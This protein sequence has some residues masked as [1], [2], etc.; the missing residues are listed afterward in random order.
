M[1]IF[2][3]YNRYI[4]RVASRGKRGEVIMKEKRLYKSRDKKVCGVC[5][6][7]AEYF[8][9]DPTVIRLM[10]VL[11]VMFTGVGIVPYI[12]GA[13]IMDD[14]PSENEDTQYDRNSYS[15]NTQNSYSA[16]TEYES[17]EP[18][19]FNPVPNDDEIK[20]FNP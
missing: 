9:V 11:L 7:I 2:W 1:K 15:A 19:G 20:G 10:Y 8:G 5:G 18:I 16:N 3:I 4:N 12:V 6:G 13:I 14:A 17:D